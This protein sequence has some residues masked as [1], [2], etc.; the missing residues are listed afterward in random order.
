MKYTERPGTK[1]DFYVHV[2]VMGTADEKDLMVPGLAD[3]QNASIDIKF[4]CQIG[5]PTWRKSTYFLTKGLPA[6]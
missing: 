1:A 3:W 5:L 2:K 6:H 4:N